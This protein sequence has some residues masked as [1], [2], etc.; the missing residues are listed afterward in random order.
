MYFTPHFFV[1]RA[2]PSFLVVNPIT[3]PTVGDILVAGT[4]FDITVHRPSSALLVKGKVADFPNL[5]DR[6]Y[7]GR[8]GQFDP[9]TRSRKQH[10]CRW[11]HRQRDSE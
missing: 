7:S 11:T 8:I 3:R 1:D 4:E 6:D 2:Y 10:W 9:Q 5:V